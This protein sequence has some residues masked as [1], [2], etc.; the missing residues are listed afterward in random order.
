MTTGYFVI[1]KSIGRPYLTILHPV[2]C[3]DHKMTAMKKS[4]TI[5]YSLLLLIVFPLLVFAQGKEKK[6]QS[7]LIAKGAIMTKAGTGYLFSNGV[8]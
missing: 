1:F 7:D 2:N 8:W 5:V 3:L 6:D 4:V